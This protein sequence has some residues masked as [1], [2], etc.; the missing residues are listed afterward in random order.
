M[1]KFAMLMLGSFVSI[2]EAYVMYHLTFLLSDDCCTHKSLTIILHT[3]GEKFM[4]PSLLLTNK[5]MVI[6]V[7]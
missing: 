7:F 2:P 4:E 6:N 3:H 5:A 1:L